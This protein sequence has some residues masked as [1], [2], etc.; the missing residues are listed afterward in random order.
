MSAPGPT[1]VA[2][3][4]IWLLTFSACSSVVEIET[5]TATSQMEVEELPFLDEMTELLSESGAADDA[6]W[7]QARKDEWYRCQIRLQ[8][9]GYDHATLEE[10]ERMGLPTGISHLNDN[11][12]TITDR[13][14]IA[15]EYL[16]C[17]GGSDGWVEFTYSVDRSQMEPTPR[18]PAVLGCMKT[19]L[20][21]SK[22]VELMLGPDTGGDL[23]RFSNQDLVLAFHNCDLAAHE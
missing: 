19:K 7:S 22:V 17:Y 14:S 3:A 20:D 12:P 13:S 5:A 18:D 9:G 16:A 10:A 11:T 2:L 4:A 23:S 8:L 21:D 15:S 1:K 6:P